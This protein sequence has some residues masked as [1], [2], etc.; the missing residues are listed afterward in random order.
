MGI[1]GRMDQEQAREIANHISAELERRRVRILGKAE[2]S[3][4]WDEFFYTFSE[5][6]IFFEALLS[7]AKALNLGNDEIIEVIL[8]YL[9]NGGWGIL[10]C[11]SSPS[12][13]NGPLGDT[14][15]FIRLSGV[16][17]S[18]GGGEFRAFYEPQYDS[19]ED[20]YSDDDEGTVRSLY[21]LD[22]LGLSAEEVVRLSDRLSL[23]HIAALRG[24]PY[25]SAKDGR[26]YIQ[27]LPKGFSN[28]LIEGNFANGQ[29]G[30]EIVEV[31]RAFLDAAG[32]SDARGYAA[33]HRN[34]Q[35]T[36]TSFEILA[37]AARD[38]HAGGP[39]VRQ[40]RNWTEA[41]Y[42]QVRDVVVAMSAVWPQYVYGHL[43]LASSRTKSWIVIDQGTVRPSLFE[44]QN[45]PVNKALSSVLEVLTGLLGMTGTTCPLSLAKEGMVE[46]RGDSGTITRRIASL[47]RPSAETRERGIDLVVSMLTDK[48]F[49]RVEVEAAI[50][51]PIAL[52]ALVDPGMRSLKPNGAGVAMRLFELPVSLVEW[53]GRQTSRQ[54][55][56][57]TG[58][59]DAL[60]RTVGGNGRDSVYLSD[61]LWVS[62]DGTLSDDGR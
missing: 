41:Q 49:D 54:P 39:I 25:Q 14:W 19:A 7:E 24:I 4:D 28:P 3:S 44:E 57:S 40:L 15:A 51:D 36:E 59:V 56:P 18:F 43:I 47:I 35:G 46:F 27:S 62:P 50:A 55:T 11:D 45:W 29:P 2:F 48:G 10:V 52:A 31:S 23:E 5:G 1:E 34:H 21:H 42:Q 12:N 33:L 58:T 32:V 16:L 22:E 30:Q 53:S 17:A 13:G 26:P 20:D 61:G 9:R 60:H 37:T 8:A 6:R 38:H